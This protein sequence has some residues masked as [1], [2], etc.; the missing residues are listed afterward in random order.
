MTEK[1]RYSTLARS[2]SVL[3]PASRVF[4]DAGAIFYLYAG[5]EALF[6]FRGAQAR[7]KIP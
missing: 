4:D 3:R 1:M 7:W 6:A 2:A 5:G